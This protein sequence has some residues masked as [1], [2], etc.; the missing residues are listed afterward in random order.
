[1][2]D[3]SIVTSLVLLPRVLKSW[4]GNQTWYVTASVYKQEDMQ[5][6]VYVKV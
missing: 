5:M 2:I 4:M 6:N 3:S 1:M